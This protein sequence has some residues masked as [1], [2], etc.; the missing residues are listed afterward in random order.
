MA[1][2][3]FLGA[4]NRIDGCAADGALTLERWFTVL[5]GN[6]L[7]VLHLSLCF[8]LDTVILISHGEVA[9]LHSL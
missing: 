5:H 8:T 9:S 6:S 3:F 1:L 7:W 4:E 2:T